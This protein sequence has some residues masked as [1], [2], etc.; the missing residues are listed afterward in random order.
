VAGR[1]TAWGRASRGVRA[2]KPRSIEIFPFLRP[3]KPGSFKLVWQ[4]R[5]TAKPFLNF[6]P[7]FCGTISWGPLGCLLSHRAL[8]RAN[9]PHVPRAT[10]PANLGPFLYRRSMNKFLHELEKRRSNTFESS[11]SEDVF[12]EG[13]CNNPHAD[14]ARWGVCRDRVRVRPCALQRRGF[15]SARAPTKGAATMMCLWGKLP[16]HRD[17]A[18]HWANINTGEPRFDAEVSLSHRVRCVECWRGAGNNFLLRNSSA[19]DEVFD[20]VEWTG[21]RKIPSVLP[22]NGRR[23]AVP[24]LSLGQ[25]S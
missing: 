16:P 14:K 15:I 19:G 6:A 11:Q 5:M 25:R 21:C 10:A 3:V 23:A 4:R 9:P 20:R 17:S 12:G 18:Y 1:C 2:L 24:S 8:P 13:S 7:E 22:L